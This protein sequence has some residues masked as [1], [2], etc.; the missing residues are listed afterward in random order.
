VYC[1]GLDAAK[2]AARLAA[3]RSPAGQF[4]VADLRE[5]LPIAD[6]ALQV[7]LNVFAPRNAAEFARVLAPTGVLLIVIPTPGHL[8]ELRRALPLIGI[9]PDKRLRTVAHFGDRFA[10]VG[11]RRIEYVMRLGVGEARDLIQM[12]PSARQVTPPMLAR[13]EGLGDVRVTASC[14]LL[15]FRPRPLWSSTPRRR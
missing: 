13:L 3:K 7:L 5:R 9:E 10:L 15:H 8:H 14:D 2:D 11:G 12:T 6:G 1:L 4:V